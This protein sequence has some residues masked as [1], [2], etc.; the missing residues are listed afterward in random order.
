MKLK[1]NKG[2]TGV[3]IAISI[4]VLMIFVALV[5]ALFYNVSNTSKK[6]ERKS[7]ASNLAIDVIEAIKITDFEDLDE[8]AESS[9]VITTT[10]ELLDLTG[11]KITL[12]NGYRMN[13]Y[14]INPDDSV[15][16]GKVVKIIK[17][18]IPYG[19]KEDD[20]VIIETLIKN[21]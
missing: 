7:T 21:Q 6:I 2:F 10:E 15:E 20:K 4:S 9:K 14:I 17:V 5:A 16:K 13:A 3:D 8:Y 1:Q 19:N 18:E 11:R 12:P